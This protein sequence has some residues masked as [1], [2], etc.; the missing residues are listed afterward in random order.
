[1][2]LMTFELFVHSVLCKIMDVLI[3]KRESAQF[4][5]SEMQFGFKDKHISL[6]CYIC[7]VRNG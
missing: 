7:G 2:N 1:M 4:C 3:L 6:S 5:T